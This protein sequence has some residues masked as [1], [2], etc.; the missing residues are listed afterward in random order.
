MVCSS[1]SP[2]QHPGWLFSSGQPKPFIVVSLGASLVQSGGVSAAPPCLSSAGGQLC[3]PGLSLAVLLDAQS[4]SQFELGMA[5]EG[6][7]F[8]RSLPGAHLYILQR[9]R[10]R[11]IVRSLVQEN[12]LAVI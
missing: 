8:Q 11:W 3:A 6:G 9:R 5:A 1:P 10:L 2:G 4:R 12:S 7:T